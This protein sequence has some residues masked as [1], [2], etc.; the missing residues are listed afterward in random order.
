VPAV[1]D[2]NG[3]GLNDLLV[4]NFLG[5]LYKYQ[6]TGI[7]KGNRFQLEIRKYLN[8]DVGLGAIPIIADLNN[9]QQ[10]EL[11]IGSDSGKM[12][13]FELDPDATGS[14]NWKASPEYFLKLPVGANP[15]FVDLDNDGDLDLIIGSEA[16]TLYYFRNTGR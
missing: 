11:I 9:D 14:I 1:I 3:D 6:R 4:G 8:L 7:N 2:L 13:S 12:K 15:V 16:G 10:P 5:Q